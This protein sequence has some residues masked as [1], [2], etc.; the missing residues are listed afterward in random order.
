MGRSCE[1]LGAWSIVLIMKPKV[2][3]ETT[4]VSY[5][6]SRPS[7][8]LILAAH[9]QLTRDWWDS[10]RPNYDVFC[11]ELVRREAARGDA[12]SAERRL[13]ALRDVPLL[14][15][16]EPA[17]DVADVLIRLNLVP[18]EYA[19]DALHIGV[20][21]DH[22]MDYLLTWNCTH[23]ASAHMRLPLIHAIEDLGYTCPCICT[24]EELMESER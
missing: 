6:T 4:V 18:E 22:G 12:G 3:L 20:A 1:V 8:D 21:V 10:C 7:R 11:S 24:P 14:R 15:L 5:Y 9:Q 23:I 2:Y 16:R 13:S 19:E 17:L